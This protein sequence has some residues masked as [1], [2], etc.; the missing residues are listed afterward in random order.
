MTPTMTLR[1]GQ[2]SR[3]ARSLLLLGLSVVK[4]EAA[5]FAEVALDL[6]ILVLKLKGSIHYQIVTN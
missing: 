4:S 3:V 1:A 6:L 5:H 2:F